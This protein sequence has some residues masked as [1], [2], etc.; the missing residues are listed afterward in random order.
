MNAPYS[1]ILQELSQASI[2]L[3]TMVDEHFG[4]NVVEFLAAGL[5]TLSHAS[6]GPLLDIAVADEQGRPTGFHAKEVDEFVKILATILE[7][8]EGQRMEIRI[9]ARQ[10]AMQTFS[11]EAFRRAWEERFWQRLKARMVAAAP[12]Q[13]QGPQKK[14]Q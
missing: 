8:D 13:T 14:S 3:S 2:G 11:A 12:M 7:M 4:I 10:R 6:A 9:R 1:T 5:L